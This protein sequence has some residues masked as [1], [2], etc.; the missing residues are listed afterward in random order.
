M[1]SFVENSMTLVAPALWQLAASGRGRRR[2]R[3]GGVRGSGALLALPSLCSSGR[4]SAGCSR[5]SRIRRRFVALGIRD[6]RRFCRRIGCR[7][8]A[9]CSGLQSG[10]GIRSYSCH[11]CNAQICCWICAFWLGRFRRDRSRIRSR[12]RLRIRI[13]PP[14]GRFLTQLAVFCCCCLMG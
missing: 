8:H 3:T 5:R 2:R 9:L 7:R 14:A 12:I 4:L 6:G 1:L 10:P 13:Q 11:Y